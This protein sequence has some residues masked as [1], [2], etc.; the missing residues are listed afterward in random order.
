MHLVAVIDEHSFDSDDLLSLLHAT[1]RHIAERRQSG[2]RVVSGTIHAEGVL[3][4][5]LKDEH[6]VKPMQVK[7]RKP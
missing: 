2:T 6:W 5:V 1:N 4:H 7:G 3:T